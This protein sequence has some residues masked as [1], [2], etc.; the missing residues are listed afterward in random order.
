MNRPRFN[1]YRLFASPDYRWVSMRWLHP[2]PP[3]Q[4]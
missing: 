2:R 1:L 4:D 3:G